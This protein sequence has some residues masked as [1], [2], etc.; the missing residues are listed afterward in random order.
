MRS[1]RRYLI[2]STSIYRAYFMYIEPNGVTYELFYELRFYLLS[3]HGRAI[4]CYE[5]IKPRT[6]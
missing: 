5:Y 2:A 6:H 3:Y 1:P 4:I